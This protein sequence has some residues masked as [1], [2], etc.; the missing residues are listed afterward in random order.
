MYAIKRWDFILLRILARKVWI[1]FKISAIIHF[2]LNMNWIYFCH[3]LFSLLLSTFVLP[4]PAIKS[5]QYI[6]LKGDLS[7][8]SACFACKILPTKFSLNT[9]LNIPLHL[10][11][12]INYFPRVYKKYVPL[13][14]IGRWPLWQSL[15][16]SFSPVSN[17]V[18][19]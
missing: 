3:F 14:I 5:R 6:S 16:F 10:I 18:L 4:G 1:I 13:Y 12:F 17:S 19:F 2:P 15:N 7:V 9:F 8:F 11:F